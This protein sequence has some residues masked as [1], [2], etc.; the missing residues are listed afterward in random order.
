MNDDIHHCNVD[1]YFSTVSNNN[2]FL[3]CRVENHYFLHII[4]DGG[5]VFKQGASETTIFCYA[6]AV[7]H[8]TIVHNTIDDED[9]IAKHTISIK[10]TSNNCTVDNR[11]V[12]NS[13]VDKSTID[14]PVDEHTIDDNH[15][16][17]NPTGS[18]TV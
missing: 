2:I 13:S 15:L 9:T 7:T 18:N 11:T 16:N 3:S 4:V 12:D 17:K 14:S 6:A 10:D 8:E 5:T 1:I